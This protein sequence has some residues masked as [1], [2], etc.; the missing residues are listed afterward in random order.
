MHKEA[1][2]LHIFLKLSGKKT[3]NPLCNI[4]GQGSVTEIVLTEFITLPH[5]KNIVKWIQTGTLFFEFL[6]WRKKDTKHM[7]CM[8]QIFT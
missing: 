3:F 4:E 2:Y 8:S 6:G 1:T 5:N 7:Y